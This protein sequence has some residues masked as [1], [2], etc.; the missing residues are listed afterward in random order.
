VKPA[1]AALC[2]AGLLAGC[3]PLF[4]KGAIDHDKLDDALNNR[5]GGAGTCV[6]LTEAKSG[7]VAYQFGAEDVCRAPLPP[8]ATFDAPSAL[9]GLDAGVITPQSVFK[10]DGSAQPIAAWQADADMAKAFRDGVQW[11]WQDLS[12]SIGHDRF[13]NALKR[14]DYGDKLADGPERSFWLGPQG[15]GAL[16]IS[17]RQQAAFFQRVYAG[18]LGL[19]PQTTR[20][21]ATLLVDEVRDDSRL[22]KAVIS[23][24]DGGC[25]VAADGS[26]G[27]TWSV[28]RLRTRDRDLIYAASVVGEAPPPGI[29]VRQKIK[30]SFADAGL[31]PGG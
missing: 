17:T 18:A 14:F 31:I 3:T 12:Q 26:R 15:G 5:I 2:V 22:G 25:A 23:G 9:I 6:V 7:A 10:W 20:V 13:A 11:W 28:G 30:D 21:V 29:E 27:V 24:A 1:A 19:K 4:G 16:T 8:C